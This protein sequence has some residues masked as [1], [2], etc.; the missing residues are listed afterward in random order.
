MGKLGGNTLIEALVAMTVIVVCSTLATAIYMNILE[1]QNTPQ[2][3]KAYYLAREI[4]RKSIG[5]SDFLDAS[6]RVE[7][8]R[9]EKFCKPYRNSTE[10]IYITIL[11]KREDDKKLWEQRE[12]ISNE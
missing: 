7:G 11:V 4:I 6:Y 5:K 12:V 1:S 8:L 9:I 3:L 2:K 10:L